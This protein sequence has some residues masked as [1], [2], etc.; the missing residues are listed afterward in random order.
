MQEY[1]P[2]RNAFDADIAEPSPCTRG[3]STCSPKTVHFQ[4][5]VHRIWVFAQQ[6]TSS[7]LP[8]VP[9][10]INNNNNNNNKNNDNKHG[11]QNLNIHKT[12][13]HSEQNK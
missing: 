1:E 3:M 6:C 13:Q 5:H 4:L 7:N 12:Y 9:I 11:H 10:G 8:S 2:Q